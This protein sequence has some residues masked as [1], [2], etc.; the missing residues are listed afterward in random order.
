MKGPNRRWAYVP[1]ITRT[2]VVKTS[3]P[4]KG[5]LVR[6]DWNRDGVQDHV[7]L[8]ERWITP[9][10]TFTA[11]EGNTG[12]DANVSDSTGGGDGVHRRERSVSLVSDFLKVKE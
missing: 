8:F 4:S 10:L 3:S 5:D 6:Y 9:G 11:I 12:K 2:N 1:W 7:G